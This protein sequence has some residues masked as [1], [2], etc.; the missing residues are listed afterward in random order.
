M[1]SLFAFYNQSGEILKMVDDLE[2]Y[3]KQA[4][5]LLE[6][7]LQAKEGGGDAKMYANWAE[8][9]LS[10]GD[11]HIAELEGRLSQAKQHSQHLHGELDKLKQGD[12]ETLGQ[13]IL[14]ARQQISEG[15]FYTQGQ[16]EEMMK[17]V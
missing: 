1:R 9:Y 5:N 4:E 17:N 13:E 8:Q 15:N 2:S 16:M 11:K 14:L 7:A 10:L 6:G 3:L 12:S